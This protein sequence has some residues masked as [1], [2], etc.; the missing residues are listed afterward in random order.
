MNAPD[1]LF[2]DPHLHDELLSALAMDAG[3]D[4]VDQASRT[5]VHH[6]DVCTR[7]I[8]ALRDIIALVSAGRDEA[9]TAPGAHLWAVIS[10][11]IDQE[12]TSSGDAPVAPVPL[13]STDREPAG[14]QS[15][16]PQPH[17]EQDAPLTSLGERRE[18]RERRRR[19]PA[20]L[21]S[22]AAA[23]ALAAG[24]GLGMQLTGGSE[25]EPAPSPQVLGNATL[26][27]LDDS[28]Q[29]RG[30]AEVRRHDDRVVLHV[31]AS[32][33]DGPDGTR[34]VWLINTDGSRMV[35]L[36]LLADGDAGDFDFPERL[37]EQGYRIVDIS[38]EPDD[39]DPVH[40]GTSLARGTIEG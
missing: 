35:S 4:E 27:S 38:Y 17:G 6:C 40:S 22:V 30:A 37:L 19:V 8:A 12:S 21:A 24:V 9:L 18:R 3:L 33:L 39:G 20:W 2:P 23:V 10:D 11:E 29:A 34:E 31:A 28:P 26:A 36:G 32:D 15:V 5:H 13:H 14:E 25:D 1:D 7:E 16:R